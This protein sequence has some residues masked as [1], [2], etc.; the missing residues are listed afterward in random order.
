VNDPSAWLVALTG[1]ICPVRSGSPAGLHGPDVELDVRRRGAVGVEDAA[2]DAEGRL[3]LDHDVSGRGHVDAGPRPHVAHRLGDDLGRTL[4]HV[5]HEE[6]PVRVRDRL[7]GVHLLRLLPTAE[8]PAGSR[9]Q[10]DADPG[11]R[12]WRAVGDHASLELGAE[13]HHQVHL[14]RPRIARHVHRFGDAR[15]VADRLRDEDELA[16]DHGNRG[17]EAPVRRGR[18]AGLTRPL[19]GPEGSRP[20]APGVHRDPRPGHGAAVLGSDLPGDDRRGS[21]PDHDIAD[22]VRRRNL[23]GGRLGRDVPRLVADDRDRRFGRDAHQ[24]ERSVGVGLGPD[25]GALD[26]DA[27]RGEGLTLLVDDLPFED[28]A[29]TQGDVERRLALLR[30]PWRG[31]APAPG[32][33]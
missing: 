33:S 16:P 10:I 5:S 13:S 17:L 24:P 26:G 23:D 8:S 4:A 9:G 32:R 2:R 11:S 15:G 28:P 22:H 25:R 21:E 1:A 27:G 31:T 29:A 7:D 6:T 12:H 30:K 3:Q 20:V 18:R 14:D 19:F